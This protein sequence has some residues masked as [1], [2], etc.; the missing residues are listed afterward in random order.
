[1]NQQSTRTIQDTR[2]TLAGAAVLDAAKAFFSGR[3]GI[4]SA[5]VEQEGPT[6]VSLRGQG[7]EEI[8][9]GVRPGDAEGVT[10]VTGSTYLFDQQVLRF[11]STL[12]P[13]PPTVEP[14]ADVAESAAPAAAAAVTA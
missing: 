8:V 6:Y 14:V 10:A 11:F 5:F 7:G 9:I 12:P 2:T 4:Y 3:L 1:M 13:A